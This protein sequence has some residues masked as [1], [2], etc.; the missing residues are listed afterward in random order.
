MGDLDPAVRL[1]ADLRWKWREGMRDRLGRRIVDLDLHDGRSEPDLADLP[2]GG[3]LLGVLDEARALTDV[4]RTPDE[5]IVA[6]DLNGKIQGYAADHLGEAAAW[7]LLAVW[8]G[9][10]PQVIPEA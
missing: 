5:W 10:P 1:V 3:A 2:T 8:E 4:V 9:K 7:A 6:V